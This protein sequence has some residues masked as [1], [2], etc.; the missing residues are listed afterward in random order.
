MSSFFIGVHIQFMVVIQVI[1]Y[2]ALTVQDFGTA[3]PA[4]MQHFISKCNLHVNSLKLF[5]RHAMCFLEMVN[6]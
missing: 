2:V 5:E 3:N 1:S 6:I 4:S